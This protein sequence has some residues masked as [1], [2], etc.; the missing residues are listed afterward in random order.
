M[1]SKAAALALAVFVAGVTPLPAAEDAIGRPSDIGARLRRC[2][3]PPLVRAA[4]T[5][6]LSFRTDGT[7]IGRPRLT[8]AHGASAD[9]E[10]AL[11]TSVLQ[12]LK[13]CTPLTFTPALG[14]AIAGR[15]LTIRFNAGPRQPE[16]AL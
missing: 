16:T 2:W 3:D 14:S 6:R 10:A 1:P 8:Y 9:D 4:V 7:I 5:I 13:S 11:A 12:A 15:I